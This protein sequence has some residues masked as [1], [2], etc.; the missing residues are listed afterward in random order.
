MVNLAQQF[1]ARRQTIIYG[2]KRGKVPLALR[3]TVPP[4]TKQSGSKLFHFYILS[5]VGHQIRNQCH[6]LQ[7]SK[8]TTLTMCGYFCLCCVDIFVSFF[9]NCTYFPLKS[10][11]LQVVQLFVIIFS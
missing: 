9:L 2:V 1:L 10:L 5:W 7:F 4:Q 11:L 8:F 6:Q 3:P